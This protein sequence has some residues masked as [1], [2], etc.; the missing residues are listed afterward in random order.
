MLNNCYILNCNQPVLYATPTLSWARAENGIIS[1]NFEALGCP[2]NVPLS[3][4]KGPRKW[5]RARGLAVRTTDPPNQPVEVIGVL[6]LRHGPQP[7][8]APHPVLSCF[9]VLAC[10]HASQR[11]EH[12]LHSAKAPRPWQRG[13]DSVL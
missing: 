3:Q 1:F 13:N 4:K 10:P 11:G 9:D 12:V 7:P 6:A 8:T 2:C 5:R